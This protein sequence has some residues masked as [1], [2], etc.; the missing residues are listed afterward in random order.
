MFQAELYRPDGSTVALGSV[1]I[2]RID[3]TEGET[4]IPNHFEFL[5]DKYCSLGQSLSYYENVKS[6]LSN[7][8]SE[9]FTS[10]R[11]CAYDR[12]ILETFEITEGFKVSLLREGSASRALKDSISLFSNR[13]D[14]PKVSFSLATNLGGSELLA[15]FI[16]N[17]SVSLP[18]RI[19]AIIGYNG[20]GKTQLLANLAMIAHSSLRARDGEIAN[21]YGR[22]TPHDIQFGSV[23][24]LS[25]SAFDTFELPTLDEAEQDSLKER[26]N[27]RGYV[28]CGLREYDGT[29]NEERRLKSADDIASD[30]EVALKKIGTEARRALLDKTLEPLFR[31]PSFRQSSTVVDFFAPKEDWKSTF[32][33]LSTGHKISLNM[34][35]QLVSHLES[36]SLVLI[37]EPESHL[38]PPLLSALLTGI[39]V[40]LEN[41]QSY[42][43]IATHSPVVLQEIPARYVSVLRRAVSESYIES[44]SIETF[45]ENLG[46]LT[47]HV[48]H[49]DNSESDFQ[50]ILFELADRFDTEEIEALFPNH[51]SA[52]A[53][54][55]IFQHQARSQ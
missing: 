32:S 42:A 19:N 39:S 44:P 28:Y 1:K 8:Y 41:K 2:I 47:R 26:G 25:Y 37:D 48:F 34:L 30:I 12:S 3:Q 55:L 54:A 7:D 5:S 33:K 17:D 51:L 43:V 31:E 36:H 21:N 35:V 6:A 18:S 23:I 11:D 16:F 38:H 45:G 22:L 24:A 10:L 49:L 27:V 53:R 20:T 9:Y 52:Q 4:N 13:V 29:A 50:H 15:N 40:A 14:D 46:L